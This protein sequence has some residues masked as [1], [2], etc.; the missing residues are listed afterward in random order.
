MY[1]PEILAHT[2]AVVAERKAAA[3]M[4]SAGGAAAKRMCRVGLRGR[5]GRRLRMAWR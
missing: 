3:D 5:C 2:R 1:L 4:R